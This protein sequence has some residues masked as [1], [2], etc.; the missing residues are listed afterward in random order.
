[1]DWGLPILSGYALGSVSWAVI[2]GKLAVHV[3]V[4]RRGSGTAGGANV[5]RLAGIGWGALVALLDVGKGAVAAYVGMRLAGGDLQGGMTA[6]V[7]SVVGH[8]LP[9]WFG[10]RGGK[11]IATFAGVCAVV[12][13][14]VIL[15]AAAM[16]V[17]AFAL[18]RTVARAS[19]LAAAMLPALGFAIGVGPD[20]IVYLAA[21]GY[22][23]CLRHMPE[24]VA[25]RH[26]R[27]RIRRLA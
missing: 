13:P 3:D 11:G 2:I 25:G 14:D 24:A 26:R 4:R 15:P 17:L 6:G 1:M 5:G 27:R 18:T 22:A 10:F 7:A 8:I 20:Q 16:W 12:A 23:I 21:A 19:A 9:I